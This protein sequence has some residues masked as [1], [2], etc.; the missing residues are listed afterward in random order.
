[1][2]GDFKF[3]RKLA[4]ENKLR[5]YLHTDVNWRVSQ[6]LCSVSIDFT[7]TEALGTLEKR[8]ECTS[9]LPRIKQDARGFLFIW[10]ISSITLPLFIMPCNYLRLATRLPKHIKWRH[11]GNSGL[12]WRCNFVLRFIAWYVRICTLFYSCR[13]ITEAAR[14]K[15][16][17]VFACLNTGIVGSNPTQSIHFCLCL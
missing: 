6:S 14:S 2:R 8:S 7:V 13:P 5:Y 16:W 4:A 17:N 1:M 15:D 10:G 12:M 11:S 9:R 3:C